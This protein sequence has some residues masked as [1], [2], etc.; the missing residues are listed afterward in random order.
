M[1]SFQ[2]CVRLFLPPA[3]IFLLSIVIADIFLWFVLPIPLERSQARHRKLRQNIPG[4]KKEIDYTR[5]EFGFRSLSMRTREKPPG[6]IRIICLGASTTDQNMQ[7]TEDI[8]AGILETKLNETFSHT[9]L[10][11]E[12][13]ALGHGGWRTAGILYWVTRNLAK[14]EPDIVITLVGINDLCLNGHPEYSY[15][16]IDSLLHS[17]EKEEKEEDTGFW[18]MCRRVSQTCRRVDLAGKNLENWW[19]LR[20]GRRLQWHS[21]NLPNLRRRYQGHL[22]VPVPVRDPD[23]IHEFT[24]AMAALLQFLKES[25]IEVIALGQPV[26]WRSDLQKKE[27]Q[28]L[29][30]SVG[31]SDGYVRPS[32]LWLEREMARYNDVQRRLAE[33]FGASHIDLDRRIPKTLEYYFDDCHFT[34]LGNEKV[35]SEIFP[36]VKE[37]IDGIINPN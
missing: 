1:F 17:I 11:I 24:D 19:K 16:G 6:T 8:W 5:N 14:F 20:A 9:G 36:V 3:T 21:S 7:N 10:K 37:R 15:S 34:D 31:S 26:L 27:I 28:K 32:L 22:Y 2:R 30:F 18:R 13:A 33:R 4:L 25:D 23:P 12:T 29:W 35:A